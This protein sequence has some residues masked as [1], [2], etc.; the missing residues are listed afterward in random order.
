MLATEVD[1]ESVKH[2]LTNIKNNHLED[3]I[4]GKNI[5]WIVFCSKAS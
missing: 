2:A 1:E 5:F 3:L 4:H